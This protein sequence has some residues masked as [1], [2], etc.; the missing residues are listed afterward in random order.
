VSLHAVMGYT[1]PCYVVCHSHRRRYWLCLRWLPGFLIGAIAGVGLVRWAKWKIRKRLRSVQSEFM[2]SVF[3]VMG[4]VCKADGVVTDDEIKVAEG[5]FEKFRLNAEQR[6]TAKAAFNRG[7]SD[8]FD[9]DAAL[10]EFMRVSRGQSGLLQMFLQVQVAAVAADGEV[11]PAEHEML[12]R[13]ARGL[14]LSEQQVEQLEALLRGARGQGWVAVPPVK[15][16]WRT[17][18]RCWAC[19]PMSVM[20]N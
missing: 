6:Q 13:V 2:K 17:P 1:E 18:I 7:K 20:P 4:A 8:D 14:G 3:A 9:L 11:H 5:L 15:R 12:V 10:A 19:R 16:N